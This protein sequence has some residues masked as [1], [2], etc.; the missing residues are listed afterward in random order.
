MKLYCNLKNKRRK[1]I[2]MLLCPWL[3]LQRRVFGMWCLCL[4]FTNTLFQHSFMLKID[5]NTKTLTS[6]DQWI[7]II[8]N[9]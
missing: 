9:K 6:H 1:I 2:E 7:I 4:L 5:S 8:Q 3:T